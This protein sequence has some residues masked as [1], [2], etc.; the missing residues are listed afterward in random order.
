MQVEDHIRIELGDWV[1][2]GSDAAVIR[3][4][5][6]VLEQGVSIEIELDS[7]DAVS[8]HA[9]A[10][11]TAG[12]ALATGRLL[13]DNHIGRMAVLRQARGLGIGGQ[14]LER[15]V[16]RGVQ[17]GRSHFVLGAQ[18]HA[19]GFYQAHGFVVEGAEFIE[20]GIPHVMMSRLE[21]IGGAHR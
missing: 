9:V 20:A 13:P 1:L 15:L 18:T 14:I 19:R 6:F 21:K 8:L 10:Y 3:H 7:F 2:L 16:Q 12:R 5:V 4:E 17:E 11:D